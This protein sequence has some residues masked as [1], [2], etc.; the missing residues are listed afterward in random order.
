MMSYFY[1][2]DRLWPFGGMKDYS[3]FGRR[4]V[5]V[6]RCDVIFLTVFTPPIYLVAADGAIL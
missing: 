4:G 1:W 3:L 5:D 6:G 2:M